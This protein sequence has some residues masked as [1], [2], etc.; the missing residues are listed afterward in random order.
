MEFVT[1]VV[2]RVSELLAEP[3][4]ATLE[5]LFG[6]KHAIADLTLAYAARGVQFWWD[7]RVA[8]RPQ[9]RQFALPRAGR[10]CTPTLFVDLC[11]TD[12]MGRGPV[13]TFTLHHISVTLE[14]YEAFGATHC[15]YLV[16]VKFSCTI[17]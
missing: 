5:R 11:S 4:E 10:C 3:Q 2:S 1:S 7:A 8:D 12:E 6:S 13:R 9:K 14:E 16:T 17:G 15:D